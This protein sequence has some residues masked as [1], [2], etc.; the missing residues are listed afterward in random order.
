MKKERT[1]V[2]NITDTTSKTSIEKGIDISV[3]QAAKDLLVERGYNPKFGARPLRKKI[4]Q[5][6]EDELAERYLLGELQGGSI[7]YIDVDGS[8]FTFTVTNNQKQLLIQ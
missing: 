4:Q 1:A 3:S 2:M 8:E 5:Y 7:V 6:I